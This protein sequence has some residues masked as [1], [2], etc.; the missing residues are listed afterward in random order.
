MWLWIFVWPSSAVT[1]CCGAWGATTATLPRTRG[2]ANAP[3]TG[4]RAAHGPAAVTLV[5]RK[6]TDGRLEA[7]EREAQFSSGRTP[8]LIFVTSGTS[9]QEYRQLA[10]GHVGSLS[11]APCRGQ[12]FF[13]LRF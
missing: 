4:S 6:L 8:D 3:E 5:P 12:H 13:D 10:H 1:A 2:S 11:V 9:L 7:P